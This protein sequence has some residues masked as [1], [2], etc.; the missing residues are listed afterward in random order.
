MTIRTLK[1]AN[2]GRVYQE[3]RSTNKVDAPYLSQ[4]ELLDSIKMSPQ[5]LQLDIVGP[6]L[7]LAHVGY[8]PRRGSLAFHGR[9]DLELSGPGRANNR[10]TGWFHVSQAD[11]NAEGRSKPLQWILCNTTKLF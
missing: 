10:L 2:I 5:G 11:Y 3:I 7:S 9:G 4:A 1:R 6:N 8:Y